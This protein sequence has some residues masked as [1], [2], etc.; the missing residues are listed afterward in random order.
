MAVPDD[1][2]EVGGA[3]VACGPVIPACGGGDRRIR[4]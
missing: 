2:Q 3:C 1:G 4:R